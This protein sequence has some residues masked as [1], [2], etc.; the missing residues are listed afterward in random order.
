M[1]SGD[2]IEYVDGRMAVLLERKEFYDGGWIIV[3]YNGKITKWDI[4]GVIR[5][6]R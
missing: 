4:N 5:V 1:N 3:L 6:Y 2:L